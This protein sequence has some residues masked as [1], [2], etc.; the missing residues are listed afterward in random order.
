MPREISLLPS[1]NIS[2]WFSTS[3]VQ[4]MQADVENSQKQARPKT[5]SGARWSSA[6]SVDGGAHTEESRSTLRPDASR[7]RS[8]LWSSPAAVGV[9]ASRVEADKRALGFGLG[10]ALLPLSRERLG[11]VSD[12]SQTVPSK[13]SSV[14]RP[15][16]PGGQGEL[17]R[18]VSGLRNHSRQY[19]Q[20]HPSLG[21]RRDRRDYQAQHKPGLDRSVLPFPS[22]QPT[23]AMPRPTQ[24]QVARPALARGALP[25]TRQA[26]DLPE[27]PKL[28]D[29]LAQLR[30]RVGQATRL[31]VMRMIVREFLRRIDHFRAYR[32]YPDLDLPTTTGTVEA[33][34]RRVRD[35]M[36]QTR[37][38]RSPQ[39]LLLWTTAMIRK[40]PL[41]LCNG[42]KFSTK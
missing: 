1:E 19:T 13:S 36:R 18:L 21:F 11:V 25:L 30:D 26:L 12:G 8:T 14:P 9:A 38:I 7:S 4:S 24:S 42:R 3:S 27:G 20:T 35:L 29:A 5:S 32:K 23:P 28:Q 16:T 34:N 37:S 40:R 39:A 10:R 17:Q 22:H 33:M 6:S 15:Y 41:V 2:F 31:R